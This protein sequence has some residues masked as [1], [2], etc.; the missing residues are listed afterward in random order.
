MNKLTGLVLLSGSSPSDTNIRYLSGFSAPDRFLFLKTESMNHLVVSSMEKGRAG[1]QSKPGTV[2]HTPA[3][4]GLTRRQSGK[5]P[6]QIVALMERAKIRRIRVATDFPAGIFQALEKKGVKVSIFGKAVCPE[7]KTKAKAELACLRESQRAAVAA[8]DAATALIGSA[9]IDREQRLRIGTGFLTSEKVRHLIHKT[10]IDRDCIGVETIVAGG[11]QATDPHE[12]GHGSLYAG[13][14]IILDIFPY[15]EKTGYWGDLSRTV[16]RGGAGHGL[17]TLYNAVKASQ[18]AALRAVGPGICADDVHAA[19]NAVFEKRGYKTEEV[20]GRHTGFIHGTGHGVGLDIHELPRVG[21]S[22]E[23]LEVGNVV[24]VEP[25]LYY[26]SL[27]GIRIEDTIAVTSKG[28][29]YLAPC[30]KKFEL[31]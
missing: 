16:C 28:W 15:S 7:R 10:L 19:A 9:R 17:K 26:P 27:G 24:T 8:M 29:R 11:D 12:R 20:D 6:N 21:T 2:V 13:Q 1:K 31:L 3:D 5:I 22:G 18:A 30:D 23:I 14:A 25:G 4:L